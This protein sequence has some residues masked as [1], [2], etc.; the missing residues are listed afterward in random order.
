MLGFGG[1]T[2]LNVGVELFKKG[3]FEKN[4][5]EILGTPVEVIQNTEDRDLFVKKLDEINLKSPV[6]KAVTKC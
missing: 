3:V 5:V 6:S 1:Q 2:A 4:N